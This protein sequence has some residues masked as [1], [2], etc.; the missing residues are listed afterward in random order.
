MTPSMPVPSA[1]IHFSLPADCEHFVAQ[2][3]P[4]CHQDLGLGHERRGLG[5][6]VDNVDLQLRETLAQPRGIEVANLL[7]E[8]QQDEQA[9]H[10]NFFN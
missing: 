8:R 1:W 7:R 3:R 2:H 5:E 6:M 10:D 4:E 9:G